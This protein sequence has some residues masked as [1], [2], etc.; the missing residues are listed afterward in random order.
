[1]KAITYARYGSPDV[2]GLEDIDKPVVADQAVLVRVRATSV[3][4]YDW[5]MMRGKPYLARLSEGLRK[6]KNGVLGL[7]VAGQVEAVGK[8]VTHLQPGDEVF[9]ARGGA[10]A[11]YVSGRNF[12]PKPVGLTFEQAA[13]LPVAGSTA[14]QA[15][16]DK[17][18]VQPGQRVLI[19]GAGGGVGTF[20]VQIAKAFGAYV[21]AVTSTGKVE[22][23]RS[24]GAD[25]VIDHSRED[26]SKT[27][28]PHDVVVDIGGYRRLSVL[29][30]RLTPT[31]TLVMV[32]PGGGQWLGPVVHVISAIVQSRFG[33]Q[34]MR[35]FLSNVN[36]DDLQ[37]LKELVEAGKVTPVIDRTYPLDETADAIRYLESGQAQG[38]VVITV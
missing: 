8:D 15:L 24:L 17:A 11:E 32:G 30:R 22:M 5:H 6:P 18:Q 21:T 36:R 12:G 7:D 20:A 31:G 34:Q 1:M 35:P 14:L 10:L 26:F 29:R 4:A 33:S 38:K 2:L 25:E 28:H 9:G 23:V 37:V 13:A 16:R 19:I 3:N 27:G